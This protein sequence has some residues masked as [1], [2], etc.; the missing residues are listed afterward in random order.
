MKKIK[1]SKGKTFAHLVGRGTIE[2]KRSNQTF[3]VTGKDF[4]ILGTSAFAPDAKELVVVENGVLVE[5]GVKL[6]EET[7][8]DDKKDGGQDGNKSN[9]DKNTETEDKALTGK[10][11]KEDEGKDEQSK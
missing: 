5:D 8:P 1:D 7:Q 10:P 6:V 11:D 9:D 2:I 3:I 4:S